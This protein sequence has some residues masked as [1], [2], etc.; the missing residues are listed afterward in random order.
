MNCLICENKRTLE[1]LAVEPLELSE[2]ANIC[3]EHLKDLVD[4]LLRKKK[5]R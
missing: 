3:D 2:K 4:Y 1:E 5:K